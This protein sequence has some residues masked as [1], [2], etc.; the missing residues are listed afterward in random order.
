MSIEVFIR[1]AT[2]GI[3]AYFKDWE[4]EYHSPDQGVK[5][6]LTDPTGVKQ[7]DDEAMTEDEEGKFVY[8]YTP[9]S[10]AELGWWSYSCT[11]QDG[12]DTEA[13]YTIKE[14]SFELK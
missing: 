2:I 11:G 6:T 12:S 1:T 4:G 9:A 8:Y 7:V 14:G 3:W 10:D 5:V 13:K